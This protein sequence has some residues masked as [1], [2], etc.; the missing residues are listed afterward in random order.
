MARSDTIRADIDRI[1]SMSDVEFAERWG[2]WARSQ[3]R[4]LALMRERWISDLKR[5]LPHAELEDAAGVE[6]VAAKAAYWEAPTEAN[7]QRRD[8]AVA[9]IQAIRREERTSR[10]AR[11]VAGDAF[12]GG[13]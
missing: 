13:G 6:L 4:D 7:R 9:N 12:M 5:M 11:T 8:A 2:E 10:P 1:S 3:D